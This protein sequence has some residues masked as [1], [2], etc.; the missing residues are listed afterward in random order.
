MDERE[1]VNAVLAAKSVYANQEWLNW[2]DAW[3]AKRD[4]S[5]HAAIVAAEIAG[6]EADAHRFDEDQLLRSS[7]T[8][9]FWA[10]RAVV[11]AL[12]EVHA[13]KICV[14]DCLDMAQWVTEVRN[15]ADRDEAGMKIFGSANWPIDSGKH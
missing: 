6:E 1:L 12:G 15:G 4:R 9:A 14:K 5:E 8:S 10:A 11:L 13:A 7:A 2:A 3:I